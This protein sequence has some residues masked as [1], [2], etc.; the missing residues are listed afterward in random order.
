[1]DKCDMGPGK[2]PEDKFTSKVP[3]VKLVLPRGRNLGKQVG[4]TKAAVTSYLIKLSERLPYVS[5][6]TDDPCGRY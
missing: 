6:L 3:N 1:M 4:G 2:I 5:D